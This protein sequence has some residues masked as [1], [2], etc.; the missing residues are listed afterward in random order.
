LTGGR[1]ETG[2]AVRSNGWLGSAAAAR[3]AHRDLSFRLGV[4]LIAFA[5]MAA[6][7]ALREELG[8]AGAAGAYLAGRGALARGAHLACSAK[9]AP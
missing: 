4:D 7:L 8:A 9:E 2:T 3:R 1:G 5:A 6:A